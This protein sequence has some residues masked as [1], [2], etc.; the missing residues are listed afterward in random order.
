[1][2]SKLVQQAIKLISITLFVVS[3]SVNA[4][5]IFSDQSAFDAQL[6][7]SITD[8]YSNPGYV[9][10]QDDITMSAVLG[11]TDYMATRFT[12]TNIVQAGLFYCAGCNGSFELGFSTTSL[13]T[14]NGIFGVGID[15][16]SNSSSLPYDA[17]VTF[18]DNSSLSI[19]LGTGARFFGISSSSLIKSIHFG[20]GDGSG[21]TTS[22]S[23]YFEISNLTIGNN[24][25]SVP[26]PGSLA[27][28]ALGFMGLA[29]NN[30][31]RRR[32]LRK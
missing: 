32:Q 25:N 26:A 7:S 5:I 29:F 19:D 9:F 18:G 28:L 13:G 21:T 31:R 1:M 14:S 17:F 16:R 3:G 8:D 20:T 11:E 24:V 22:G 2:S 15:I 4:T 6:S 27:L 10:I 12:N 23:G 30:I